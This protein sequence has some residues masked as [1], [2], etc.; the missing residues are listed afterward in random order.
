MRGGI[1]ARKRQMV[2]TASGTLAERYDQGM[3][4]RKKVA[5]EK[6]ADLRGPAGRNA[7]AIL[8][9]TDRFRVPEL[10]PVR[11]QRMLKVHSPSC[12]VRPR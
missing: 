3:R 8:A 7:V 4:V 1:A 5:R 9:A 12:A 11:Y 2:R 10:V 6:H